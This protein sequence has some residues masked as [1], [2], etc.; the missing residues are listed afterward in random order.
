MVTL[1]SGC[2]LLPAL[3]QS[4]S[5]Q[6]SP[7]HPLGVGWQW[8]VR[9]ERERTSARGFAGVWHGHVG[10][11]WL[12][13][14]CVLMPAWERHS[15]L[16]TAHLKTF[17]FKNF[18]LIAVY[19]FICSSFLVHKQSLIQGSLDSSFSC[20][21]SASDWYVVL[22]KHWLIIWCVQVYLIQLLSCMYIHVG[23]LSYSTLAIWQFLVISLNTIIRKQSK[24]TL[25]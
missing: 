12:E 15:K 24:H 20:K 21:P 1:P 4:H 16:L 14:Y 23:L 25:G 10:P 19:T 8:G 9:C 5:H 22:P 11:G 2:G 13:G 6:G 17:T 18:N 3:P 7:G